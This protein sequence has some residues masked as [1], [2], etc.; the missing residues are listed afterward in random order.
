MLTPLWEVGLSAL[1]FLGGGILAVFFPEKLRE[2]FLWTSEQR[3]FLFSQ[4][5]KDFVRS[6][7]WLIQTRA[8]GAVC[9]LIVLF[10]GYI[11]CRRIA[12]GEF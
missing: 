5:S 4:W 11:V 9:F 3:P 12:D 7:A 8:I 6:R 10:I 2:H 1:P